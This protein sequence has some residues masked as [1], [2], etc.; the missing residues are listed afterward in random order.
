[1]WNVN[2]NSA[3]G[4]A[5]ALEFAGVSQEPRKISLL[6]RYRHWITPSLAADLS[7]GVFVRRVFEWTPP[8]PWSYAR[9]NRI[10]FAGNASFMLSRGLGLSTGIE[11]VKP[12]RISP[13]DLYNRTGP[14]SVWLGARFAGKQ[15]ILAG[16]VLPALGGLA[17]YI[18]FL[19]T[20]RA[21]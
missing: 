9:P 13:V 10:G 19:V 2:A 7:T 14:V 18:L 12:P 21:T 11:V 6:A 16:T 4:V 20:Y 17:A 15:G 8:S 3:V 1:M 5:G